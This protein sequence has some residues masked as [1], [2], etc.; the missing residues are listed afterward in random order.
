M[1]GS[2]VD[3]EEERKK[4]IEEE[5]QKKKQEKQKKIQKKQAL[6]QKKKEQKRKVLE[7]KK[8]IEKAYS[9]LK[10]EHGGLNGTE[11]T[12]Y[13]D[14]AMNAY[15]VRDEPSLQN[16]LMIQDDFDVQEYETMLTEHRN[17]VLTQEITHGNRYIEFK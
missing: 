11:D 12:G 7:R 9:K 13:D 15:L 2:G 16:T 14:S 8:K 3:L 1:Q 10:T 17:F 6:I 5:K 4:K